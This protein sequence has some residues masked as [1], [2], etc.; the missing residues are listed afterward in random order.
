MR[1]ALRLALPW[2]TVLATSLPAADE[3]PAVV[4][5]ALDTSGSVQR[6]LPRAQRLA[7]EM[8]QGLPDGSRVAVLTFDDESRVVL[9][10]SSDP[11]AVR[12]AIE[13]V[14]ASGRY[15]ALHD[16]LYDASRYLEDAPPGR[17]AIV[18]VSDGKDENSAL[19][20]DDGLA[21]AV[22]GRIPVY[23]VGVGRIE[24]RVLRRIAKLTGGEFVTGAEASG[25][26][27]A[28]AIASQPL[29]SASPEA[30]AQAAAPTLDTPAGRTTPASATARGRALGLWL[31]L[32]GGLFAAGALVLLAARRSRATRPRCPICATELPGPL[33]D[34]PRCSVPQPVSLDSETAVPAPVSE[35][36]LPRTLI[37]RMDTTNE[38]LEKTITLSEKPLLMVTAGTGVGQYYILSRDTVTS[39]GRAHANDVVLDDVAISSQHCRIRPEGGQLVLHD[40]KSTNGTYVNEQRVT[41]HILK[42]GDLVR[43]GET[44]LQFR[45]DQKRS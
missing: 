18:L 24:E 33:S 26:A 34:C 2:L 40:L 45:L 37:A 19:N 16:A 7:A 32:L 27:I 11:E 17:K 4:A 30:A 13:S 29:P 20:L 1:R 21:V 12:R 15:T 14:Q 10:A 23:V 28:T 42:P 44:T 9:Q 8:L 22:A 6:E 41:R 39:I 36:D 38:Y 5:L 35:D 25:A 43:L 3:A 31:V